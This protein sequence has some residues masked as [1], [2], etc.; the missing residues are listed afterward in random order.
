MLE[1]NVC[2]TPNK[3]FEFIS[4]V[5]NVGDK[6]TR[7]PN[8]VCR[9]EKLDEIKN[10]IED[11]YSKGKICE[12]HYGLLNKKILVLDQKGINGSV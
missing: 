7:N 12:L 9:K 8:V 4:C 2:P 6:P 3:G 5:E 1:Q 10:D 11:A